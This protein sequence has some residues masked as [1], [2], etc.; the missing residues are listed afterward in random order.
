M[1]SNEIVGLVFSGN[2]QTTSVV[3]DDS[4][5]AGGVKSN[6][7]SQ[8]IKRLQNSGVR[9]E[10][11]FG[12]MF[13]CSAREDG[14][15]SSKNHNYEYFCANF[16]DTPLIGFAGSAAFGCDMEVLRLLRCKPG[17]RDFLRTNSTVICLCS[18]RRC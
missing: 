9:K 15:N 6:S 14:G 2:L 7:V 5:N 12:L 10:N 4:N 3:V 18:M 17:G 16:P 13:T 8:A 11:S 1:T